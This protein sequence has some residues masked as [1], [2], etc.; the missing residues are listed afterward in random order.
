MMIMPPVLIHF[1]FT[2]MAPKGSRKGK[3][4]A[5]S[6]AKMTTSF[7]NHHISFDQDHITGL[8]LEHIRGLMRIYNVCALK[9]ERAWELIYDI[10]ILDPVTT[11]N[12]SQFQLMWPHRRSWG[13][14]FQPPWAGFSPIWGN[15]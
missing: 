13:S 12:S 14:P 10:I 9:D 11:R 2:A 7:I 6:R 1:E 4:K 3:G 15:C 8:I 5:T